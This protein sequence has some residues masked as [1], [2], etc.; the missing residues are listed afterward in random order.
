MMIALSL[1]VAALSA[2]LGACLAIITPAARFSHPLSDRF[3]GHRRGQHHRHDGRGLRA[4][5]RVRHAVRSGAGIV[6]RLLHR[7]GL[8]LRIAAE[9]VLGTLYRRGGGRRQWHCGRAWSRAATET[10][11]VTLAAPAGP[12]EDWPG[13]DRWRPTVVDRD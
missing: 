11:G 4:V 5:V 3:D 7:A 9:D 6:S 1:V 8:G 13:A 10:F 12:L 2:V